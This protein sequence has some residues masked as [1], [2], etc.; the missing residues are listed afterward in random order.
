[1]MNAEKNIDRILNILWGVYIQQKWIS[2][3]EYKGK[4]KQPSVHTSSTVAL[5]LKVAFGGKRRRGGLV[6]GC[7]RALDSLG[8]SRSYEDFRVIWIRTEI[9]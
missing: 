2:G 3:C 1:M 7:P 5:V 8:L 4:M 9:P 6:R